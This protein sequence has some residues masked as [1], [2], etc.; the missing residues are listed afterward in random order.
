MYEVFVQLKKK[1]SQKA[2]KEKYFK[3]KQVLFNC[4]E[5]RINF[6]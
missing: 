5:K 4:V 3:I 6:V 2:L 1:T